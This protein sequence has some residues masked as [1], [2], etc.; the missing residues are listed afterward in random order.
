MCFKWLNQEAFPAEIILL[1]YDNQHDDANLTTG[2][3]GNTKLYLGLLITCREDVKR[4]VVIDTSVLTT[5]LDR[6]GQ[7]HSSAVICWEGIPQN[8]LN[9]RLLDEPLGPPGCG[10]G[11]TTAH[12]G[13][14]TA[15]LQPFDAIL[16]VFVHTAANCKQL[17]YHLVRVSLTSNILLLTFPPLRYCVWKVYKFDVNWRPI[18]QMT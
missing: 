14:L 10:N 8:P 13:N 7:V 9:R 5:S 3:G 2:S 11:E 6:S 16:R 15:I 17:Y 18:G 1:K 12:A 4:S